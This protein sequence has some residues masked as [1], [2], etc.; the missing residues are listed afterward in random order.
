ME[1]IVLYPPQMR[2]L[3]VALAEALGVP[4]AACTSDVT[5]DPAGAQSVV[6]WEC[7][8]SGSSEKDPNIKVRV[9]ALIG[10]HVILIM[11][12]DDTSSAFGQLSLMMWLQRFYVPKADEAAA[13]GKWKATIG[14]GAFDVCSVG[15]LTVVIPWYRYCQMERSCRWTYTAGADKPW[16]NSVADGP[17][18]DVAAAQTYAAI[19]SADPPPPP[20][21]ASV[22]V[23]PLPPKEI[24]FVDIHDDLDG[25]PLVEMALS[26]SGKWA[27]PPAEYDLVTGTGT[28]F[29]SAFAHFLKDYS[30][31]SNVA[32]TFVV[33]PDVGAYKRFHTMVEA[34]LKGIARENVLYIEKKRV[35]TEVTQSAFLNYNAD[36]GSQATRESLPT[37]A[38]ILIP[39]DFTNSGS[40]L[41]GGASIVRKHVAGP[42]TVGAF[43]SHFVAKYERAV[44]DK[45]VAT[46]YSENGTASDMDYFYTTD[47]IPLTTNWLQEE[48]ARRIA[49][50]HPKR[51]FLTPLAPMIAS[52]VSSRST[53]THSPVASS[54]VELA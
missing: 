52:W 2:P 29:A 28:Y 46:L 3:G 42:C 20:G 22:P 10:K 54:A 37:G 40:T 38:N 44:V 1:K 19:L 9:G 41:F 32:T 34:Q 27:N 36:D 16:S 25:K 11:S 51:V 23:P 50:G 35:G 14:A 30:R 43:V 21:S 15:A 13:K 4:V 49:A 12:Q 26:K 6:S 31:S 8:P 53:P 24:L 7:F 5:T 39:D 18:V 33:F 48:A 17:F 45:F 47:S